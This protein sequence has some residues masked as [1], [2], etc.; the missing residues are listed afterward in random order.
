MSTTDNPGVDKQVEIDTAPLQG[1]DKRSR[2]LRSLL[3]PAN[4]LSLCLAIAALAVA[5]SKDCS[6]ASPQNPATAI[7]DGTASFNAFTTS[8]EAKDKAGY[9]SSVTSNFTFDVQ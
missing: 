9:L 7:W 1:I 8:W 6:C 4:A 3:E 5:L 2:P